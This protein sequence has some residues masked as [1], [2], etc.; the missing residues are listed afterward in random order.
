MVYKNLKF[1]LFLLFSCL[2][3]NC[4]SKPVQ[5]MEQKN[6]ITFEQKEV[7]KEIHNQDKSLLLIL[8]YKIDGN[9]PIT[10][11]YKVIEAK[12]KKIIKEGVFIGS[13]VEWLDSNRLK[14]IEH[15]GIIKNSETRNKFLIVNIENPK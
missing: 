7:V 14:C 10:F 12:N 9:L 1:S 4:K 6:K 11:N 13:K 3:F 5:N 15:F 2:I 8:K